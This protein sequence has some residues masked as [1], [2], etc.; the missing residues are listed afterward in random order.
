V[1]L[2]AFQALL[3]VQSG[4]VSRRQAT[5]TGMSATSIASKLRSRRWQQLRQGVYATFTGA[6]DRQAQL[7]A[8]LL[9][10]GPDAVLSHWTAA[11]LHGLL[12]EPRSLVHVTV[13]ASRCP[14]PIEGTVVH[15]S[16]FVAEA[17]HPVLL[18]PRTRIE[19]TVLDL[20]QASGSFDQ[21]FNW[22]CRA[23]GRR[24]TTDARLRAAL[25]ARQRVRWRAEL[26]VALGD[27]AEGILSPLERRYVY[28][29]ERAHGLP[30]ARRQVKVVT[31]G[32]TRYLDNLYA[33]AQLAVEL[34]GRATH[35]PERRWADSHRDNAHASVGL[36]TLRYNWQDC[37]E[38][39]CASASQVAALLRMRG[40]AVSPRRCGPDCSVQA[41]HEV[42]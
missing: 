6:P 10:A 11:E 40:M 5:E 39:A 16:I 36:L 17:R 15:R 33:E 2:D 20:T 41:T 38:L 1:T 7:W 35:P 8:V 25:E 31:D 28:G 4:V 22:V 37:T 13:P 32:R 27:V 34:D 21:A 26:L 19:H 3:E 24:L 12:D 23:V 42:P 9:R 18:P 30:S 29:V 14:K